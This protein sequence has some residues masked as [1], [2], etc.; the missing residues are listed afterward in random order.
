VLPTA[1]YDFFAV[2]IEVWCRIS[3]VVF[4]SPGVEVVFFTATLTVSQPSYR[5][6]LTRYFANEDLA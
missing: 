1:I 4:T 2:S 3:T 5:R 6:A